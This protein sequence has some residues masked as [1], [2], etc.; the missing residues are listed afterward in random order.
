[1]L[2]NKVSIKKSV[3]AMITSSFMSV[4][5]ADAHLEDSVRPYIY[6]TLAG[7]KTYDDLELIKIELMGHKDNLLDYVKAV[8]GRSHTQHFRTAKDSQT[9]SLEPLPEG[10]WKVEYPSK[11]IN[12][13]EWAGEAND[14]N[15]YWSSALGPAWVGIVPKE[16]FET[17]RKAIGFHLDG[18]K[19][20]SPGTAGCLG[21]TTV[22]DLKKFVGWFSSADTAPRTVVVD[23]GLGTLPKTFNITDGEQ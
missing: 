13:V 20:Q 7:T 5:F 18:N 8:S 22:S 21:I 6:V 3:F 17:S 15:T 11:G 14:Y 16:G 12:G 1:M 10:L 9:G 23:W 4:A 19:E 2:M